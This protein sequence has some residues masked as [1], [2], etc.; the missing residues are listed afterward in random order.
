[1][2][3]DLLIIAIFLLS[4][5]FFSGIEIAFISANKLQVEL[6]RKKGNK[7]GKILAGFIDNPSKFLGTTLVGNNIVLVA[8]SILSGNFLNK[9][10][11]IA[12]FHPIYNFFCFSREGGIQR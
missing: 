9:Y 12:D 7:R 10:L 8:L 3:I 2:L 6:E 5:G 1:M 4:S 11:G